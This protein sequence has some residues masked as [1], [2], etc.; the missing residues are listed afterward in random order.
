MADMNALVERYHHKASFAFVYIL[1]AH[2]IDEWPVRSTN[3]DLKQHRSLADRAA[4]A[5]RLVVE[6]PLHPQL[7]LL[8]DNEQNEFNSTYSSW[9]FRYWV[10]RDGQVAVKMMPDGDQ[11]SLALLKE[12][13]A[14]H[15]A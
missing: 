6:Y 8:L 2:A 14:T 11:V 9:P 15:F 7:H 1:E 4:A 12:W 10:I 13:C 5:K 3:A